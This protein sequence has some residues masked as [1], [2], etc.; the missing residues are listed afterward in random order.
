MSHRGIAFSLPN[1]R[2][3]GGA[4]I[5]SMQMAERLEKIGW[6]TSLI[7]HGPA[8]S[9]DEIYPATGPVTIPCGPFSCRHAQ[10]VDLAAFVG[11][12]RQALPAVFIPNWYDATY[13]TCAL[14]SLNHAEE[15][16]VIAVMH[17]DHDSYYGYARYYEPIIHAFVGVSEEIGAK[18][19]H[20][21]PHRR[22][23]IHVRSYAVAAPQGIRE[24]DAAPTQLRV[25]YAGRIKNEQKC[26]QDLPPLIEELCRLQVDFRFRIIG[27]GEDLAE[28][29]RAVG[30]LDEEAR[31]RVTIE[32][33]LPHEAMAD[34]WRTSDVFI[35]VSAYEGS[36][37][38][39]REAMAAGC[40][41]VVTRVSGT[42]ALIDEGENGYTTAVGDTEAMARRVRSLATEPGQ[43]KAMSEQAHRKIAERPSPADDAKWLSDVA[44]SLWAQP[45]RRWPGER[46]VFPVD[47]ATAAECAASLNRA[48]GGLAASRPV[49]H[50]QWLALLVNAQAGHTR[51]FREMQEESAR[52]KRGLEIVLNKPPVRAWSAVKRLVRRLRQP[53]RRPPSRE[54]EERP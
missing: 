31:S 48:R 44:S 34:V 28:L 35:L 40:V 12:Y 51:V 6:R 50:E 45:A 2:T 11:P 26:I 7:D 14:L 22:D 46:P 30:A 8:A 18:L 17:S 24:R 21:F 29:R 32:P 36:S 39:M 19:N 13:A 15:Q 47:E 41:P 53:S 49:S 20:M 4:T 52:Y 38:A 37:I 43:L 54:I 1:G 42:R 25:V 23:A 16:R 3:L 27:E 5:W 33:P 9:P 10:S